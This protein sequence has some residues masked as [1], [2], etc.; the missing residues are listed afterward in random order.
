MNPTRRSSLLLAALAGAAGMF[1]SAVSARAQTEAFS[2]FGT[3]ESYEPYKST[4]IHSGYSPGFGFTAV[5]GGLLDTITASILWVSGTNAVTLTLY[6]NVNGQL[7][8]PLESLYQ[9][10]M[11]SLLP[12]VVKPLTPF[13]STSKSELVAGN[14]YFLL[15][16][17]S[18]SASLDWCYN[19]TGDTGPRYSSLLGGGS[20]PLYEQG[21]TRAAFSVTVS[22]VPEPSTYAVLCGVAALGLVVL[23]RRLLR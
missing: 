1:L 3:G 10:G 2:N 15:A 23:R 19:S 13:V 18:G 7:G 17:A 20:P 4:G 9:S 22:P 8:T 21:V 6:T 11:P 14:S 16:S 12:Q 5:N